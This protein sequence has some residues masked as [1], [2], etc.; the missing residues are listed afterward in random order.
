[1]K[2]FS[3]FKEGKRLDLPRR[4]V[5]VIVGR[6]DFKSDRM[7]FGVTEVPPNTT[8]LPH[9]HQREEEIIYI[10]D[11]HGYA[12][13]GDETKEI[14]PGTVIIAKTGQEHFICNESNE[15]MHFSFCFSPPL[16]EFPQPQ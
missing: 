5:T 8:M 10:M 6:D 3:H 16:K 2:Y 14:D 1:M 13:V 4:T 9:V 7:T 15:S 12:Q 11:G